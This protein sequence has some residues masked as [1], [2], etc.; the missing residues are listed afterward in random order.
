MTT[1]AERRRTREVQRLAQQAVPLQAFGT[2]GPGRGHAAP[3][4]AQPR[5]TGMTKA[6]LV[7]RIARDHPDILARMKAGEFATVRQAAIAAGI[8]RQPYAPRSLRQALA[9]CERRR[10]AGDRSV[11]VVR[12]VT[13][14][15]Q[16]VQEAVR[17]GDVAQGRWAKRPPGRHARGRGKRRRGSCCAT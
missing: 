11:D 2:G 8:L 12:W 9:Q 4:A 14:Q 15:G 5:P 13:R 17:P 6:Y 3:S 10:A 16:A 7:A 1:P